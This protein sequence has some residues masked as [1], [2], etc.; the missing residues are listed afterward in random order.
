MREAV[1]GFFFVLSL[2]VYSFFSLC[3]ISRPRKSRPLLFGSWPFFPLQ[4][5]LFHALDVAF[6]C[7]PAIA[8]DKLSQSAPTCRKVIGDRKD[9]FSDVAAVVRVHVAGTHALAQHRAR[10]VAADFVIVH[11]RAGVGFPV[12][13]TALHIEQYRLR[14]RAYSHVLSELARHDDEV[15]APIDGL[16]DALE[17]GWLTHDAPPLLASLRA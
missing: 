3:L 13:G 17:T 1:R 12:L 5:L 11:Y 15:Q 6:F 4:S 9:S 8:D 14:E 7:L 16:D 10:L 2:F